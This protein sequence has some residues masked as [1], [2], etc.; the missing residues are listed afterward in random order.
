MKLMLFLIFTASVLLGQQ[1]QVSVPVIQTPENSPAACSGEISFSYDPHS[2]FP[3][4][5][6]QHITC[7]NESHRNILALGI[8]VS[9]SSSNGIE[10]ERSYDQDYVF[11][12]NGVVAGQSVRFD[13]LFPAFRD[14]SGKEKIPVAGKGSVSTE[15]VE[16]A[17]GT[18]WG[19]RDT[20]KV[21][22]DN[23]RRAIKTMKTLDDIYHS[24]GRDGFTS[25]LN[26]ESDLQTIRHLQNLLEESGGNIE[27]VVGEME[28][29]LTLASSRPGANQR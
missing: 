12:P 20:A 22:L 25:S 21:L 23:R 8:R 1:R 7:L 2:E 5:L 19:N 24:K 11:S 26:R 16:F 3:N 9:V 17:D 15:F 28:K 27:V 10:F 18:I 29:F 14:S 13:E 4:A 6:E